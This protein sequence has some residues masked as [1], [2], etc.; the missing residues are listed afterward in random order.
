MSNYHYPEKL[1]DVILLLKELP[2]IGQRGAER[3]VFSMLKWPKDKLKFLGETIS[4]LSEQIKTCQKCGNICE[5]TLCNICKDT[6]RNTSLLCV[7]E[8]YTQIP[9]L[10][11]SGYKGLYHILGGKLSPLENKGVETLS[12]ES[13]YNRIK[14]EKPIEVIL[15]LSQDIEGQATTI[16]IAEQLK[17]KG[18]KIS[19]LARGIPAGADIS[20]A[21]SATLA[22]AIDGRISI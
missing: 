3:I 4:C 2:G 8:D 21:N 11:K 16:Y 5:N 18:I 9:S 15:A 20:Y 19:T 17:D 13:L 10:E 14:S 1:E 7:L 22:A 6:E 12:L